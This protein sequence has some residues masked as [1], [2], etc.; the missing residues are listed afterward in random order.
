MGAI[1]KVFKI[2]TQL[3]IRNIQIQIYLLI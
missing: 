1:T 2:L 3:L